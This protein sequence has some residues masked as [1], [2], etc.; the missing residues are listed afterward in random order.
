MKEIVFINV[1]Y[2]GNAGDFWSSPLIYYDFSKFNVRQVHYMDVWSFLEGNKDCESSNITDSLVIIGGGGLLTTNDNFIQKTTEYLV[3]NNK[4]IFWGVGSNTYETPSFNIL[5]HKN[6]IYSGIRDIS[7]QLNSE[8]LPCVSCKHPLFDKPFEVIDKVGVIEHTNLPVNIDI[9]PKI[10]NDESIDNLINFISSKETIISTTYHGTYWSQLLNKKVVYFSESEK[11][12]SKIINLKHR[13]PICNTT[14][15]KE[16]INY[17]S[18]SDG[19]LYESRH[20]NDMFYK[21]VIKI[22]EEHQQ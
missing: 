21:K 20:L 10:K 3:E 13:V 9:F 8:Y 15:F 6:V 12:N 14:N 18:R 1:N 17:A 11:I 16:S 19:M 4:V 2:I 22:L 5:N 7:Y